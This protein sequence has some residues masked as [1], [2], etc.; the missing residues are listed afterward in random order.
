[1]GNIFGGRYTSSS[2]FLFLFVLEIRVL[3]FG[4]NLSGFLLLFVMVECLDV[5]VSFNN[6]LICVAKKKCIFV[7]LRRDEARVKFL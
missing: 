2:F 4:V 3:G 1:M 6:L 5:F 7:S